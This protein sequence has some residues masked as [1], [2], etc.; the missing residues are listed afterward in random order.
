MHQVVAAT[1]AAVGTGY[2]DGIPWDRDLGPVPKIGN[3]GTG[4]RNGARQLANRDTRSTR[5]PGSARGS[6]KDLHWLLKI[7][8]PGIGS[9]SLP[10]GTQYRSDSDDGSSNGSRFRSGCK[11]TSVATAHHGLGVRSGDGRKLGRNDQDAADATGC[12]MEDPWIEGCGHDCVCDRPG[13]RSGNVVVVNRRSRLWMEGVDRTC[14][15]RVSIEPGRR[16]SHPGS[17]GCAVA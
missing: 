9:P 17:D 12:A 16:R 10:P 1:K 2:P 5:S 7:S 15:Y 3:T 8:A 11:C 4:V 13:Q 14:V 6:K